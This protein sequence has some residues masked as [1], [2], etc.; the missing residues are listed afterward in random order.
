MANRIEYFET[1][2]A[3]GTSVS[4]TFPFAG[5]D[6]NV[7]RIRVFFPRGCGGLVRAR[8]RY[9]G[10]QVVP[11]DATKAMK[12]NNRMFDFA[13]SGY[14]V[15]TAWSMGVANDGK[16]SHTIKTWFHI[17]EIEP[18]PAIDSDYADAILLPLA[19]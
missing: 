11:F 14:P 5:G 16:R 13:I 17:D 19:L 1:T 10:Q 18:P 12:G 4:E 8:V 9:A 6:G 2:C 7:A 3:A 15:G